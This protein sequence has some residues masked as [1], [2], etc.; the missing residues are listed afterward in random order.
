[1]QNYKTYCRFSSSLLSQWSGLKRSPPVS[2]QSVSGGPHC[3]KY[4][5]SVM[6]T[7][8]DQATDQ[9][10]LGTGRGKVSERISRDWK[11]FKLWSKKKEFPARQEVQPLDLSVSK[12][13]LTTTTTIP[14]VWLPHLPPLPPLM[15]IT[16]KTKNH[17][18][19]TAEQPE[20]HFEDLFEN[21]VSVLAELQG[22]RRLGQSDCGDVDQR[23]TTRIYCQFCQRDIETERFQEHLDILH[24]YK[25]LRPER[26]QISPV[27]AQATVQVR[28]SGNQ[29]VERPSTPTNHQELFDETTGT[30][31]LRLELNKEKKSIIER[32]PKLEKQVQSFEDKWHHLDKLKT[33]LEQSLNE[34]EDSWAR[35]K[36]KRPAES[37]PDILTASKT[38][39]SPDS[40][41]N[42]IKIRLLEGGRAEII[43]V[44]VV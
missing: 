32:M 43:E 21:A 13:E 41:L 15:E 18:Q 36:H 31:P 12:A 2:W 34:V 37:D 9:W 35:E 10:R 5:Q 39:S 7:S 33:K 20:R 30:G 29:D 3:G 44:K 11:M 28:P 4:L 26:D 19:A 24:K 17:H 14:D 42:K 8:E 16:S 23:Q 25:Y 1:M 6:G 27:P 40:K 38:K 22:K